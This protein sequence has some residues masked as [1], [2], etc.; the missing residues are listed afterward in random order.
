MDGELGCRLWTGNPDI[1][2]QFSGLW[3]QVS[4]LAEAR[5]CKWRRKM[6]GNQDGEEVEARYYQTVW[7][8]FLYHFKGSIASLLSVFCFVLFWD[9]VSVAKVELQPVMYLRITWNLWF[10]C[11]YLLYWDSE[12]HTVPRIGSTVLCMLGK[13]SISRSTSLASFMV[14]VSRCVCASGWRRGGGVAERLLIPLIA[15][16][17]FFRVVSVRSPR[18]WP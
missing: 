8:R 6:R 12:M 11:L 4:W 18:R 2:C 5:F 13:H 1:E 15:C 14:L 3:K 7:K 9:R 17:L 10:L 16:I